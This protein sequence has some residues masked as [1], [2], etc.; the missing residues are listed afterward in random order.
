LPSMPSLLLLGAAALG[1]PLLLVE[2]NLKPS[3]V[4]GLPGSPAVGR[5]KRSAATRG[6]L[7]SPLVRGSRDTPGPGELAFAAGFRP[8]EER[9]HGQE[10]H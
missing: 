9:D 2:E 10:Q 6:T 4:A 5:L 8:R 3:T 1:G 7:S